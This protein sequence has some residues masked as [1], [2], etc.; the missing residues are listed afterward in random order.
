MRGAGDLV[1]C[2]PPQSSERTISTHWGLGR[3][4]V[5]R[6]N[7]PHPY[8]WLAASGAPI[9]PSF[10]AKWLNRG[11]FPEIAFAVSHRE[12]AHGIPRWRPSFVTPLTR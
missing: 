5:R 3:A 10:W 1:A 12:P 7:F 8:H 9:L 2:E 11:S 4:Q 6:R